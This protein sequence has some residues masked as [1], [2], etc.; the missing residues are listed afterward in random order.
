M[1]NASK[2]NIIAYLGK[3]YKAVDVAK[4][5]NVSPSYISQLASDPDVA[6]EISARLAQA[7]RAAISIDE[8]YLKIEELATSKIA[9][10][11]QQGFYKPVE[12]LAVASMAN[13]AA[14]KFG[15]SPG[16]SLE[17]GGGNQTI[18]IIL[19]DNLAGI[20]ISATPDNQVVQIGNMSL[21]PPAKDFIIEQ[22]DQELDL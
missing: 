11:L 15:A 14:K 4:I 8:N 17:N 10:R 19:P 6:S 12:L 5:F 7:S 1:S 13:K 16:Q 22:A 2:D 3:G 20:T 18:S 9:E 21:R